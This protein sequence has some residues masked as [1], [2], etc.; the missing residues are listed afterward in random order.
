M[1]FITYHHQY[2]DASNIPLSISTISCLNGGG[3]S[4]VFWV[5]YDVMIGTK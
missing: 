2:F 1:L 5:N 4:V 3:K